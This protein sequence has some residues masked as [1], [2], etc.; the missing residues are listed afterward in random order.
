[1][2]WWLSRLSSRFWC[3]VK[4]WTQT[5]VTPRSVPHYQ[6]WITNS[7]N[8]LSLQYKENYGKFAASNGRL[9]AK[10]FSASG[11]F[12][13]WPP[14]QGLCPW[15]PTPVIGSRSRA[16]HKHPLFDPPLFV[17]F[18]PWCD[19]LIGL[20]FSAIFLRRLVL[21][22]SVDIHCKVYEDRPRG[23]PPSGV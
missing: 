20:K 14:D 9:K 22:Q 17:T 4:S 7:S 18:G 3:H 15:T 8:L 13:L 16:R 6:C 1:M 19:L 5:Q 10:S 23:T 12:A 21:W 2:R 11:G